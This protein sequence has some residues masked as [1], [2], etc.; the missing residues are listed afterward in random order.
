MWQIQTSLALL[1]EHDFAFG[2][3]Y[4]TSAHQWE[5]NKSIPTYQTSH[6]SFVVWYL[7]LLDVHKWKYEIS[8]N[9][10]NSCIN[11]APC[12][13]RPRHGLKQPAAFVS[14]AVM[15]WSANY[16]ITTETGWSNEKGIYWYKKNVPSLFGN[17]MP[18]NLI[19]VPNTNRAHPVC[20]REA[21]LCGL[22]HQPVLPWGRAPVTAHT[23]DHLL[24]LYP[25]MYC[26]QS[27][28]PS[29]KLD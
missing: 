4:S 21:Q 8:W 23:N 3:Q 28:M 22:H 10:A 6:C 14:P 17:P 19:L 13:A 16:K 12:T 7:P 29:R 27:G 11:A 24:L 2:K 1:L 20:K 15:N 9:V 18:L 25:I 26:K 5:I